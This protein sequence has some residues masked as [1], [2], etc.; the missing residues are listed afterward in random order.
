MRGSGAWSPTTRPW[1]P[2]AP[3]PMSR[4][5]RRAPRAATPA[6]TSATP[7]PP[8][9]RR[10]GSGRCASGWR[11]GSPSPSWPRTTTGSR[12]PAATSRLAT[13]PRSSGSR[14][15][16][17]P[18]GAGS[19]RRSRPRS[20]TTPA[21]AAPRSS[22]CPRAATTSRACTGDSD[23]NAWARPG[24][25]SRPCQ[26]DRVSRSLDG[27]PGAVAVAGALTIAFSAILV[28][29]ADVEPATAAIFRCFYALPVLGWLED[30]RYGRRPLRQRRIAIP[31][32]IF[33][34]ADLIFWHH[35]IADVGAGLATVLGNTQVVVV[36][37][38][39]WLI[40]QERVAGRLLAAL[41][42]VCSGVVLISGVLE[43]GA[44]GDHPVRGVVYGLLTGLSYAAFI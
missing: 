40:L 25:P 34:A 43:T 9:F 16:R 20:W 21:A 39:A 26:A 41:P 5:A 24:S 37:F 13:S 14:R 23:S 22:S 15:F 12:P 3:W 30:R 27:R 36:P 2:R 19:A 18:A 28:K 31:A 33:F 8:T 35:S 7:P 4:S 32:G 1:P 17:A 38:A 6:R 44:Y 11:T 10:R 42:L 29:L